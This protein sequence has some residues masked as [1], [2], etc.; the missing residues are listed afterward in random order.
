MAYGRVVMCLLAFAW[1]VV[2]C[3]TM[4]LSCGKL[5]M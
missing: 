4:D 3:L 5:I 1:L 2:D